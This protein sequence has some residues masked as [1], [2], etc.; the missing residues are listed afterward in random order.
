MEVIWHCQGFYSWITFLMSTTLQIV[1]HVSFCDTSTGASYVAQTPVELAS[2][3]QNRDPSAGWGNRTKE[4]SFVQDESLQ[5]IRDTV[6][7]V[8]L[9][10]ASL[11][12]HKVRMTKNVYGIFWTN[13]S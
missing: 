12:E 4:S 13:S 6:I 2:I 3:L 1:Q 11:T 5:Y 10:L 8:L 7:D 9:Y